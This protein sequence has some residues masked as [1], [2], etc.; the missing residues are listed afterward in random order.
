VERPNI[1]CYKEYNVFFEQFYEL[2][3]RLATLCQ[4]GGAK[5]VFERNAGR[6]RLNKAL[7]VAL[8]RLELVPHRW[9]HKFK[10]I[11]ESCCRVIVLELLAARRA[12]YVRFDE[13]SMEALGVTV[14]EQ[15]PPDPGGRRKAQALAFHVIDE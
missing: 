12:V 3:R 8:L 14:A 1:A 10:V 2:G 11:L 6:F 13:A 4:F 5:I 7:E 9:M 15:P